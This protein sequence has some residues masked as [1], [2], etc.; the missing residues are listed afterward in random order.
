MKVTRQSAA[1]TIEWTSA[2]VMLPGLRR[3]Q[4][5]ASVTRGQPDEAK[6]DSIRHHFGRSYRLDEITTFKGLVSPVTTNGPTL[7][8]C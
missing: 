6:L 4:F 3:I 5:S 2:I 1:R 8:L 7:P